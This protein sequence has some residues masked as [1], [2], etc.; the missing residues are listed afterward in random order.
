MALRLVQ[1][2]QSKAPLLDVA[3][4]LQDQGL[5]AGSFKTEYGDEAPETG[6]AAEA[7]AA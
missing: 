7:S 1:R 3:S 5:Q 4:D 6:A 2:L